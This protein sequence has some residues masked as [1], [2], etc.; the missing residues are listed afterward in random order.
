MGFL[1]ATQKSF[2]AAMRAMLAAK[3][4]FHLSAKNNPS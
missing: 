1:A 4:D 2:F 3:N